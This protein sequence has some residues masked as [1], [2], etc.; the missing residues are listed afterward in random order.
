MRHEKSP[1][2][3]GA[4]RSRAAPFTNARILD[5]TG[6]QPYAGDVLVEQNRIAR[7]GRGVRAAHR[8]LEAR[9]TTG[10]LVLVAQ[11]AGVSAAALLAFAARRTRAGAFRRVSCT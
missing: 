9:G 4:C 7:V 6:G 1:W 8:D 10:Q 2:T 11:G 5:G 3:S